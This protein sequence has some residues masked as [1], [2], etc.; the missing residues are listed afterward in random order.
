MQFLLHFN[1]ESVFSRA[2]NIFECSVALSV[3]AEKGTNLDFI[4]HAAICVFNVDH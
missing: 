4:I 2:V 3:R 1:L